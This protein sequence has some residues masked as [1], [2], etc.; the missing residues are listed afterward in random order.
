MNLT[1]V[2]GRPISFTMDLY[3]PLYI[4]RPEVQLELYASLRPQTYGQDLARKESGVRRR[5]TAP[6]APAGLARTGDG[7]AASRRRSGLRRRRGRIEPCW[8]TRADR[9]AAEATATSGPPPQ[10]VQS[11]AQAGNVGNLFQ[12]AIA[13]PVSLPRQQSAMLPIVNA[14][15][16][17]EKVSI[18]N[19]SVQ[20]K[21]PLYGLRFTNPTDLYL[22]QGPITV[23]DGG[24]YAGDAKIEDLP[25]G[26]QRLI[27]YGLDLDTEVAPQSKGQPEELLSVRLLK[28]TLHRHPQVRPGDRVHG[29]ELGQEGEDRA[30]RVPDRRRLGRWFR[31]RSRRKRPATCTALPWR[32]SRASRPSWRS[33]RSGPTASR[34]P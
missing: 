1:L 2:S 14:D 18:Y 8:P 33:T 29:E 24:V 27:S 11:A 5:R 32:P 10:G 9:P 12:Y 13:T 28:G 26:S 6:A 23:F 31:P 15:V 16:K 25:P 22:M 17:G 4:P 30:D 19:A 7:K 21:H 20:A 3:Q 34:W